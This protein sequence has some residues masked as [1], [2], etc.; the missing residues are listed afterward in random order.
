MNIQ[1]AEIRAG[2][3]GA[4]AVRFFGPVEIIRSAFPLR[5][6]KKYRT[7]FNKIVCVTIDNEYKVEYNY[8]SYKTS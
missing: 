3:G 5:L 2:T 1:Q 8:K 7:F 4:S 6:H